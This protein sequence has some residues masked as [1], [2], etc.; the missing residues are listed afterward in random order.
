MLTAGQ[1][2]ITYNKD[3][4]CNWLLMNATTNGP[5]YLQGPLVVTFIT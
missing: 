3:I 2:S 4:D 5:L 1:Y